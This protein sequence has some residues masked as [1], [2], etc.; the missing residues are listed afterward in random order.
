MNNYYILKYAFAIY[1]YSGIYY[2]LNSFFIN[3]IAKEKGGALI[4][5]NG[6]IE[7]NDNY[8]INQTNIIINTTFNNNNAIVGGALF[9]HSCNQIIISSKFIKNIAHSN[10]ASIVI[11]TINNG[12]FHHIN[13]CLFQDN[14]ASNFDGSTWLLGSN[15]LINNCLFLNNYAM[16][17]AALQISQYHGR[18]NDFTL[19]NTE[20]SKIK[21]SNCNFTLN[22]AK[23]KGDAISIDSDN[24]HIHNH[25]HNNNSTLLIIENNTTFYSN[26]AQSGGAI[27]ANIGSILLNNNI[28]FLNNNAEKYGGCISMFN[29]ALLKIYNTILKNCSSNKDGVQYIY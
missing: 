13:N 3:N 23:L 2:I 15:I 26:K 12:G 19:W 24:N 27:S 11:D 14:I 4:N 10:G 1:V 5:L 9:I 7:C 20:N 17:G 6:Y 16:Y 29:D 22:T 21:I 18:N 28:K 25:H 8:N